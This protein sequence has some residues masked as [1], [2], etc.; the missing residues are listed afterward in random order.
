MQK[1]AVCWIWASPFVM[2]DSVAS[3]LRLRRPEG[4]DVQFFQGKGW[5][6]AK[7]HINACEKALEWGADYILIIGADQ[8]YDDDLLI[9]LTDRLA[10]GYETMCALVPTRGYVSDQHMKPFMPVASRFKTVTG[11]ID[12]ARMSEFRGR[13]Y[14]MNQ[15]EMIDPKDGDVQRINFI[16]SG[17]MMFHRDH[18][19]A[20]PRPWFSETIDYESQQRTASMDVK[21]A[22]K[23]QQI[24]GAR[25]WVDTTIKV[26]HLH[27]FKI[28]ETYQDRFE[29]WEKPGVGDPS[30]CLYRTP[31][32]APMNAALES[33]V[34]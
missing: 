21:F 14:D 26:R 4:W 28:D 23:L 11:G 9:R 2:T 7:R 24:A 30:I 3:M 31:T 1:L 15:I 29:D 16:G 8:E 6:P 10:E 34:T 20:I 33:A 32:S 25:L 17:V 13:K 27:I 12:A 19:L 5:G 22:W 18:I